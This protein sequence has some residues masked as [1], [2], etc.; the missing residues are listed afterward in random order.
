G[1]HEIVSDKN[2]LVA[3][4]LLSLMIWLFDGLTCYMVSIAVGAQISII[5]VILAVSIGNVGK[6]APAT[7]GSV[8]I[9]ESIL[10]SVLI[11]FGVAFDVAVVIA[12]L[13]HAIKKLFNLM[14]GVPATAGIG[15]KIAQIYEMA[16][17]KKGGIG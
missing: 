14:F 12:I 9:Y 16:G 3:S 13:D 11:F 2:L 15:I 5:A 8:G 1:Y 4:I 17:C 10:V 7:P 6:I